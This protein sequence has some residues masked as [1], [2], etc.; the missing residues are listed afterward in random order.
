MNTKEKVAK[1]F[2]AIL[3]E[4][5]GYTKEDAE[6][7]VYENE[8]S[9]LWERMTKIINNN[10]CEHWYYRTTLNYKSVRKCSKCKRVISKEAYK[11]YKQTH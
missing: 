11:I 2:Q 1:I 8:S 4:I 5:N 10:K 6:R 7:C 9:D 3:E